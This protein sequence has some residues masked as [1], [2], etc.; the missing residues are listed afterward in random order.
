MAA[1]KDPSRALLLNAVG[2]SNLLE[3]LFRNTPKTKAFVFTSTFNVYGQDHGSQI[4]HEKL[5]CKPNNSLGVSKYAA[6]GLVRALG[7]EAEIKW[8]IARLF[9]VYG[10]GQNLARSD[11]GMVAIYLGQAIRN[12]CVE[13]RGSLDRVR[14]FVYIDDVISALVAM[15]SEG[16]ASGT[17]NVCSEVGTT[18]RELINVLGSN[19][20]RPLPVIEFPGTLGDS[21]KVVGSGRLLK[22]TFSLKPFVTLDV[23][24]QKT[25]SWARTLAR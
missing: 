20:N 14:D 9:N 10:P 23:G 3:F 1:A 22:E 13:V 18:V 24:V 16:A 5:C 19:L 15:G 2:T 21:F 6:E 25:T 17:F 11:L 4:L 12:G 7:S 8:Y